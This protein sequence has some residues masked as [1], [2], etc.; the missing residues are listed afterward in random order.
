MQNNNGNRVGMVSSSCSSCGNSQSMST[1]AVVV[2]LCATGVGMAEV[3][4]MM[5]TSS[6]RHNQ[7]MHPQGF[8]QA[9]AGFHA[10]D[11]EHDHAVEGHTRM[12]SHVVD[13][14]ADAKCS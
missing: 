12:V 13:L 6:L 3:T 2:V 5:I 11:I 7:S 4:V 1:A 10:T 9:R 8:V 14:H